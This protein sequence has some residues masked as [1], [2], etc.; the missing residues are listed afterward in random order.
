MKPLIGEDFLLDTPQ[1]RRL[2]HDHA[3]GLPIV[4]YHCHIPPADIAGDVGL[5]TI[6]QAWL[7]GDHYK[8]RAMRAVGTPEALIT[9]PS[10][11]YEKFLAWAKTL[12]QLAGNPLYHWT[13][14]E[15]KRYFDYDGPL[16]AQTAREVYDLCNEKLARPEMSARSIIRASGVEWIGTTD[17]PTDTLEHHAALAASDCGFAVR[18]A[19]RPD[20]ALH[21]YK[22]TFAAYAQKLGRSA[23]V[24][25]VDMDSLF[26]ALDARMDHFAAHGCTLSDHG[27]DYLVCAELPRKE[28]DAALQKALRGEAVTPREIAAYETAVLRH[29]AAEYTRRGWVMQLHFSAIRNSN[30]AMFARVGAD[31]GFDTIRAGGNVDAL[32]ALLDSMA[33]Q[34]ELPDTIVYS[35]N[36]A[37]NAAIDA[38]VGAFCANGATVRHG[39]AWWFNDTLPGMTAHLETMASIGALGT[40][41]GMLT[42]SRSLLSYTRHEYFRRILC[43]VLGQWQAQGLVWDDEA[44]LGEL[45]Q[46]VSYGNAKRFLKI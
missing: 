11:D 41:L 43:R 39:A 34:N 45:V 2:Y 42:D 33:A 32:A 6:T 35:L 30:S 22:P 15:L 16:N 37:D 38:I 17:D 8:W 19:F 12:P 36:P 10:D 18:P 7:G 13:Y 9:G 46:N 31:T 4:D 27:L 3:E 24:D 14:L 23:G 1:A 28:L 44:A 21:L 29:V 40:F 26:A 20:P 5:R 25:I